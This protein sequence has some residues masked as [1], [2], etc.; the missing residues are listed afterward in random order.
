MAVSI[1]LLAFGDVH[2]GQ[3]EADDPLFGRAVGQQADQK[4]CSL[5]GADFAFDGHKASEYLGG[6]ALQAVII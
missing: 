6:I 2:A 4:P 1:S 5:R 3:Y